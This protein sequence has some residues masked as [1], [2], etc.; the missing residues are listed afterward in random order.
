MSQMPAA[1][2]QAVYASPP[3]SRCAE[4]KC[5]LLDLIEMAFVQAGLL[6]QTPQQEGGLAVVEAL[7]QSKEGSIS[8]AGGHCISRACTLFYCPCGGMDGMCVHAPAVATQ[9][10]LVVGWL[11]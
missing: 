6:D 9:Q 3:A 7:L 4:V 8:A 10:M 2:Q 11:H 5:E 1:T